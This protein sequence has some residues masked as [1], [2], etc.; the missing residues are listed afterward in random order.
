LTQVSKR[1]A[2]KIRK[3]YCPLCVATNKPLDYG[4]KVLGRFPSKAKAWAAA[5]PLRDALE[6]PTKISSSVPTVGTLVEQY[7]GEKM[8]TRK[9]TRGGYES[10][11]RVYILP[12][13]ADA[14][15][16]DLQARPVEMWLESLSLAPKSKVHIRGFSAPFG[17]TQCGSKMCQCKSTHQLS[18]DKRRIQAHTTR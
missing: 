16:R 4:S 11:L 3:G 17:I 5:K 14:P 15:I 7:R 1:Y 8:P 12:R 2:S 9:D 13:W 18:H 6:T 10:W